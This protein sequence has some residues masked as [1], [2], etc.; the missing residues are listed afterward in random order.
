VDSPLWTPS[1]ERI[2]RT[3]LTAFM[4][5]VNAACGLSLSAYDDLYRF[6]IERPEDF[7]R[8]VWDFCGVRGDRGERI[9]VDL[10]L[11]P[12][13]RFFRMRGSTLP[14]TC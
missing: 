3:R 5:A 6:S 1:P 4:R 11:M 13:A 9:V 10:H 12:G 14:T 8:E 7:W 2:E